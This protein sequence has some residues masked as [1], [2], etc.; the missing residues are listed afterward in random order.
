MHRMPSDKEK[1]ELLPLGGR[2]LKGREGLR[3][4][5]RP[6]DFQHC[7][8]SLCFRLETDDWLKDEYKLL[9]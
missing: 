5:M 6:M 9:K 1:L 2:C 4:A 7:P 3:Y 8:L